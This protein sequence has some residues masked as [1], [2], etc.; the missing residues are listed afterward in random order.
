MLGV[1]CAAP[2]PPWLPGSNKS[3]AHLA[4]WRCFIPPV[5][6]EGRNTHTH[7]RHQNM[8]TT[9]RYVAPTQNATS[10]PRAAGRPVTPT[11][12]QLATH[13]SC[14]ARKASRTGRRVVRNRPTHTIGCSGTLEGLYLLPMPPLHTPV[15]GVLGPVG[16]HGILRLGCTAWVPPHRK[17]PGSRAQRKQDCCYAVAKAALQLCASGHAGSVTQY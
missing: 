1:T 3:L 15:R 13:V 8:D 14:T 11:P 16:G 7:T 10:C 9:K 12:W 6:A 5:P 17:T 4:E 2:A